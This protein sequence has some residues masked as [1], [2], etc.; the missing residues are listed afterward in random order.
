[1]F[2][3]VWKDDS[4]RGIHEERRRNLAHENLNQA[5][6]RSDGV[7]IMRMGV[8]GGGY[9]WRNWHR[10]LSESRPGHRSAKS[11][12][13]LCTLRCMILKQ[14]SWKTNYLIIQNLKSRAWPCA[15]HALNHF[16]GF[17]FRFYTFNVSLYVVLQFYL[18]FIHFSMNL[19]LRSRL[20]CRTVQSSDLEA[21]HSFGR[22]LQCS[23]RCSSF[24][25]SLKLGFKFQLFIEAEFQVSKFR[26]SYFSSFKVSLINHWTPID[27]GFHFLVPVIERN[28]SDSPAHLLLEIITRIHLGWV[29]CR[30]LDSIPLCDLR[31][32]SLVFLYL[33]CLSLTYQII[34]PYFFAND[35]TRSLFPASCHSQGGL[36]V[37]ICHVTHGV[38]DWPL[39]ICIFELLAVAVGLM[40]VSVGVFIAEQQKASF[41]KEGLLK[42]K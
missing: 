15:C 36:S 19:L 26:Q 6:F 35:C 33:M 17:F 38:P 32:A 4:E 10:R 13:Q 27:L 23:R 42:P 37:Q 9:C 31:T 40:S 18:K 3:V 29:L 12:T 20:H 34:A 41:V 28:R 14:C 25:V 30:W 24:K 16:L 2:Q 21:P 11:P 8:R 5:I 7:I 22:K 1:M 39:N